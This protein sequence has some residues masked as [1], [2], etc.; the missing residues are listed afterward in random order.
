MEYWISKGWRI[1]GAV[2][3]LL[4]IA[5]GIV[6]ICIP[7]FK[8]GETNP[9][10]TT[11]LGLVFIVI[12]ALAWADTIKTKLTITGDSVEVLRAFSRR[13]LSLNE[14]KG[15]RKVKDVY[16][17]IPGSGSKAL[18]IP[19][20]LENYASVK[21]WIEEKFKDVDAVQV[22]EETKEILSNDQFGFTVEDR[23]AMLKKAKTIARIV[24]GAATGL[25][26]WLLVYPTPYVPLM[27][28]A[29]IL[30][31]VALYIIWRFKGIVTVNDATKSAY[32][33]MQVTLFFCCLLLFVRA[34]INYDLY[35]YQKLWQWVAVVTM[36]LSA[37]VYS[38]AFTGPHKTINKKPVFFL[39]VVLFAG[40]S[41]GAIIFANC[42]Y[43]TS[44]A[45][46][47][48]LPVID[49]HISS[50]K[51]KTYYITTP[52]WG[53]FTGQQDISVAASVYESVSMNDTVN[54]YLLQGKLGIPW[55]FLD[56]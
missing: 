22:E 25:A 2:L 33:S 32:P 5:G 50:G 23:E 52:A 48:K 46:V 49:K 8:N 40:Y 9:V 29:L 27:F 13:S 34:M 11:I 15:Y 31:V 38:I 14:I 19:Q 16:M 41:Y 30:P 12:A 10:L 7:F 1:T 51:A 37:A 3:C 24:N 55:Y 47:Y 4:F 18:R 56:K 45:Q 54:I 36:V 17:L 35:A 44:K 26:V 42:H 39:L 43:D 53:R 6:I 21:T 28:A 20:Y